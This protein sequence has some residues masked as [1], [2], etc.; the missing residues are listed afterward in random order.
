VLLHIAAGTIALVA[1]WS[2]ALGRKGSTLHVRS[3][4]VFWKAMVIICATAI[5]MSVFF[6]MR[7]Q[8][9]TGTFLI[10][11]V[12]ITATAMWVGLRAIRLKSNQGAFLAGHYGAVAV[13]NLLAGLA[14]LAMGLFGG[15]SLSI[16]FSLIGIFVGVSMLRKRGRPSTSRNWWI[17]EHFRAMLGCGVATHVA[18]LAIGL[19]RLVALAGWQMPPSFKLVAWAAPV[20]VSLAAGVWLGRKYNRRPAVAALHQRS[21]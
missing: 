14:V 11:L 15:N 4:R 1:Y 5:P 7:G 13:A 2:A 17:P 16:G 10:Y 20:V 21:T 12:I 19:D 3:G 18:F 6:F 9:G 8:P